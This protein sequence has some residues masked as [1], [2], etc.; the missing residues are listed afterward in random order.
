[1]TTRYQMH[2]VE[3][4]HLQ[5]WQNKID[6]VAE[7]FK[8]P[9]AL[10]MRVHSSQIE[11]LVSSHSEGNPYEPGEKADLKTNLYCETVMAN[12]EQLSVPNALLDDDWKNNPDIELGMISY[13]GIPLI[14]PNG[15]VFGTICVLDK[16]KRHF[17]ETYQ[18]LLWEFKELIETDFVHS[19]KYQKEIQKS[20]EYY[21]SIF[22]TALYPIAVVSPDLKFQQVNNAFCKLMEFERDELIETM[23]IYDLT[24]PDDWAPSRN[25]MNKLMQ[26][27]T[28]NFVIDKRYVNQ[29]GKVIP[30]TTYVNAIFNPEGDCIGC[31]ASIMDVTDRKLAESALRESEE[32]HRSI[33]HTAM[34]GFILSD[35][36]GKILEANET[37][38]RMSGYRENEL[39]TMRV[40]D[41]NAILTEQEM[42]THRQKISAKG[43]DRFETQHKRSDGTVFDVEVS[44]QYR[45]GNGGLFVSFLRDI[46]ERRKAEKKLKESRKILRRTFDNAPIGAAFVSLDGHFLQVNSEFCR[47]TG[48]S[49][50]ELKSM[51]VLDIVPPARLEQIKKVIDRLSSGELEHH[52]DTEQLVRK[53]GELCWTRVSARSITDD[54]GKPQFL[55][56]MLED[57]NEQKIAEEERTK[58]EKRLGQAQKMEA[59]GTLAGGIAHDFNNILAGI[60][61]YSELLK[62][63]LSKDSQALSNLDNILNA[64]YRARDLVQ[65]ILAFS[66]QS[67]QEL[68]PVSVK[69]IVK[70]AIKLLRASLPS[71]IDIKLSIGSD[72]MVMGDPTQIHQIIMNLCTNAGHAM[73][74][75]GGVL[76]VDLSNSKHNS[77]PTTHYPDLNPGHYLVL[78]VSDTGYG[79]PLEVLA[80]IY[81]PFFTTKKKGEGTG[82]GLSVVHGIVESYG[83]KIYVDSEIGKGSNFT[84]FLPSIESIRGQ[85]S[86]I[87]EGLP[88]GTEHILVV[89]DEPAVLEIGEKILG[90]LG[91]KV[92]TQSSSLE[93]LNLFRAQPDRFD[94]VITDLTMPQMT[95][96]KLA[97]E[98]TAIRKDISVILC[99]GFSYS[100]TEEKIKTLGIKG[101]LMKPVI[102]N[103]L[104]QMVRK[105]LDEAKG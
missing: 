9:A 102:M 75:H 69:L 79:M 6:I 89:D 62:M 94:L 84:V 39:L 19:V 86:S 60:F 49:E 63:S 34:D 31:T 35:N 103:D 97:E 48:Y 93:A 46:T 61:G 45:P 64:G 14:W 3:E 24:H 104:A 36:E 43:E 8:V 59:I 88:N 23:S 96:D 25:L 16:I 13:L 50:K 2:E 53:N 74:E 26:G 58:L 7:L 95:G 52:L 90:G 80:R 66:R 83:G 71:T 40:S 101:L 54:D 51:Q 1:M 99:T 44:I 65:Q 91:Y 17:S 92:D 77:E 12:K 78:T 33:L 10:I 56:P 105:V 70:E 30:A 55:F 27:A 21:R 11:V 41:L 15:E 81:D 57:V 85:E 38:C 18:S 20:E 98:I 5:K 100:I 4:R 72:S 67:E 37:Y 68:K 32:Q 29:S 76:K 82:M 73:Q 42:A 47:L 87:K 28:N 22:D